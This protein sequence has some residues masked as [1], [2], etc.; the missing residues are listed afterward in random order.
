ME[1]LLAILQPPPVC[2]IHHPHHTISA[3]IVVP[4]VGAQ[5]LLTTNIPEIQLV[6]VK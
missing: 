6:P 4:P 2:A 1:L 5:G 3:L